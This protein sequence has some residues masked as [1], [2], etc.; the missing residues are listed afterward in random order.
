MLDAKRG[1]VFLTTHFGVWEVA[2]IP[3][4]NRVSPFHVL[5]KSSSNPRM[6]RE[7]EAL[8]RARQQTTIPAAGG[9]LKV[10]RAMKRGERLGILLDQRVQPG[11]GVLLPFLGEA[12]WSSPMLASISA[13]TG[14]PVLPF[15]C[16]PSGD[17]GYRVTFSPPIEPEGEGRDAEYDLTRRYLDYMEREIIRR[18]DLWFWLHDRWKRVKRHRWEKTI[19]RLWK[20]SG[21]DPRSTPAI[22]R[23]MSSFA[24]R[25]SMSTSLERGDSYL[26]VGGTEADR[27]ALCRGIG[28]KL[29]PLGHSF[30]LATANDNGVFGS[31]TTE[32]D[33]RGLR[34][35]DYFDLVAISVAT[36]EGAVE[37]T[38][39]SQAV[40]DLLEHRRQSSRST[41]IA[42]PETW[43]FPEPALQPTAT[44]RT[45]VLQ[46]LRA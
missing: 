23:S 17:D 7:V 37:G 1:I 40:W 21:L 30:H 28:G 27:D 41:V 45:G 35:L 15:V 9:T 42:V 36:S 39:E 5:A 29:I 18:P 20:V 13:R 6:G 31:V 32:G 33:P 43:Q 46:T 26:I 16:E 10:F 8:R 44:L 3:I 22:P 11:E 2:L 38:S 12:A 24:D 25:A 4:Q 34:E 14:A 19:D